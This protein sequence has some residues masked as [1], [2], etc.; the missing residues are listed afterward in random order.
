[1]TFT[2][3]GAFDLLLKTE[4]EFISWRSNTTNS[5]WTPHRVQHYFP[6]NNKDQHKVTCASSINIRRP[7]R[8][9]DTDAHFEVINHIVIFGYPLPGSLK[10][11]KTIFIWV[12]PS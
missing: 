6:Y 9:D 11:L 1:M 3:L 4:D 12:F 7:A 2:L 8:N 5:V 10:Q